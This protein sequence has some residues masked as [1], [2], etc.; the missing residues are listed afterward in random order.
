MSVLENVNS[1]ESDLQLQKIKEEVLKKLSEYRTTLSYMASDAPISIL[2]L[3]TVTENAL[4]QHGLL[5]VYDL[6][7]CDFTEVKGL[8]VA[9]IRD[10]TTRLDQF[11]AMF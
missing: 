3:P 5:R 9:R 8:G 2:C 1:V 10:L 4:L 7:N 6:F 11:I